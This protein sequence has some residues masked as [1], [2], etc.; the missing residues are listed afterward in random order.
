VSGSPI[1]P[2]DGNAGDPV[3]LLGG[4]I[5]AGIRGLRP[6]SPD[7]SLVGWGLRWWVSAGLDVPIYLD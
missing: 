4:L 2:N 6:R 7:Y 1:E 3:P 5:T